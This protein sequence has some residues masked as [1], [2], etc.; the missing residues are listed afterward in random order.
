M[1]AQVDALER[2][3]A[4]RIKLGMLLSEYHSGA[5]QVSTLTAIIESGEQKIKE[6]LGEECPLCG[7]QLG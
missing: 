3:E 2:H 1:L 5:A 4:Q 6:E 7:S